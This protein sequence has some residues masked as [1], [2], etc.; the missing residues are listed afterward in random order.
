[1]VIISCSCCALGSQPPEEEWNKTFGGSA[2]DGAW[3]VED[4]D[5]MEVCVQVTSDG[6]CIIAG[7]T[8]SYG[9]GSGDVWLIKTDSLGNKIWDRT[10]GSSDWDGARFVQETKDGGY[11][12]AGYTDPYGGAGWGGWG[13]IWLIKT[14]SIG[15][16]IWDRTFG[17]WADDMPSSVKET[18]DGGYIIAGYTKSYGAGDRDAWLI[19]TDSLGNKIWDKKFGAGWADWAL[20]VQETSDSGYIIAGCT[21]SYGTWHERDAWLIKTDSLGNQLWSKTFGGSGVEVAMSA[22]ETR[23]GGYAIVGATSSFGEGTDVWLIKT[24]SSGNK[25]WDRT[26]GGPS[27]EWGRS[28][29]ETKDG[30]FIIVGDTAIGHGNVWLIKTDDQGNTIWNQTFGGPSYDWAYSVQETN[31]GGYI[32]SAGTESYGAGN[33]DIWLVK[34]KSISEIDDVNTTTCD[35]TTE[36]PTTTEM[37]E[38]HDYDIT[39]NSYAGG[40]KIGIKNNLILSDLKVYF[41]GV[42]VGT[43]PMGPTWEEFEVEKI[44]THVKVSVID[45]DWYKDL[46]SYAPLAYNYNYNVIDQVITDNAGA[47]IGLKIKIEYPADLNVNE[48]CVLDI[49]VITKDFGYATVPDTQTNIQTFCILSI[50]SDESLREE[51]NYNGDYDTKGMYACPVT[52]GIVALPLQPFNYWISYDI[53]YQSIKG[54]NP[55]FVVTDD[56]VEATKMLIG[57]VPINEDGASA[58]VIGALFKAAELALTPITGIDFDEICDAFAK[59]QQGYTAGDAPSEDFFDENDHDCWTYIFGFNVNENLCTGANGVWLNHPFSFD[60]EGHHEIKIHVD[61]MFE[62]DVP[63]LGIKGGRI[64]KEYQLTLDVADHA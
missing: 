25:I 30:G 48:H 35:A 17:G 38:I 62:G 40:Y 19:K 5:E 18:R 8:E 4:F 10:F 43:I 24:D 63:S 29:Q 45:C 1:M 20:S 42:Q 50:L 34:T 60:T 39:V 59:W 9:A 51:T 47:E 55:E 52:I 58:G 15:N 12:I 46:S 11:I 2:N 33:Y 16:K 49:K 3:S 37:S 28:I 32:F 14:D 22:L 27:Y 64:G 57:E 7:V 61:A 21:M 44:P 53:L 56:L 23:D 36:T 6:G 26:F 54:S 41:D 13:D 31:D